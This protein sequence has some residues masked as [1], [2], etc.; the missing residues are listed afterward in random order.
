MEKGSYGKLF[1]LKKFVL[2][3]VRIGKSSYG[4]SSYGIRFVWEKVRVGKR[5]YEKVRM[6]NGSYCKRFVCEKFVHLAKGSY[7]IKQWR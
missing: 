3:K 1:V 4:K 7:E 6:E 5:S 2:E